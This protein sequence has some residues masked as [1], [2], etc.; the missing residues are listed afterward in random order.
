MK[1]QL[2]SLAFAIS[3]CAT[4]AQAESFSHDESSTLNYKFINPSA[5]R[6]P[7]VN[8]GEGQ[9]WWANYD[10]DASTMYITGTDIAERY[11]AAV[12]IPKGLLSNGN[13]TV[14][15]FSFYPLTDCVK[16]VKVWVC[17]FLPASPNDWVE[18]VEL[19]DTAIKKDKFNDVAFTNHH[20]IPQD[21]LYVGVTFEVTSLN[22]ADAKK[23][24]A[25][26]KS[27]ANREN[28]FFYKT[29]SKL[30]WTDIEGNAY[31]KVLFGGDLNKNAV[32]VKPFPT[33]YVA[34]GESVSVPVTLRNMGT[35]DVESISY[36]ITTDG[37][38]SEEITKAVT[39]KGFQTKESTEIDF[40]GDTEPKAYNKT[41]TITKVNGQPNES[42]NNKAVGQIIT[43]T[44]TYQATP[45]VE[46]FV[47]TGF[48]SS[49]S[50]LA[51]M[52]KTQEKYGDQVVLI[53]VHCK[54]MNH[55]D[56]MAIDDYLPLIYNAQTI[57][58]SFLDR[59]Y[60]VYPS[61]SFLP[62]TVASALK[63]TVP[64]KISLQAEWN[65]DV[66]TATDIKLSSFSEFSYNDEKANYG[67][68]YVILAD[69]LKGTGSEWEQKNGYS[70]ES[71]SEDM[72][73]W[74]EAPSS[75]AGIE[76]DHVAIAAK[77]I[78]SGADI[79]EK[80]GVKVG[81]QIANTSTI[82]IAGNQLVQDKS[83]LSAV[84][85]LIDRSNNQIVNAAKVN[86]K[87]AKDAIGDVNGDGTID[88]ADIS[89]IISVM[90][91]TAEYI[92][93]DVNGDGTVDVADI[94][95]VISIMAGG[96]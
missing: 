59:E 62:S 83:K 16:N 34:K 29:A 38:T 6:T 86:I 58:T 45:V 91:G 24:L 87:T 66:E 94:S 63:R 88:V 52:A 89:A 3:C 47:G 26:T 92:N 12:F 13:M 60:I 28:S 1:K 77:D 70:G 31:V 54:D 85:L 82:S 44:N 51:G 2:L 4:V 55:D 15:G 5:A 22:D 56:P 8:A 96:K 9:V 21:G 20:L 35:A 37:V 41:L 11:D 71:G 76:Y 23:P 30:K 19:A 36:T 81:E 74:R 53:A 40:A 67:V 42:A 18:T 33:S 79:C 39:I 80:E 75:V 64:A 46:V 10:L 68:A 93:A 49:P 50:A 84:A 27:D 7:V 43:V 57:P 69:G 14:D 72:K 78:F 17:P 90:A 25:F 48:S 61:P 65:D 32:D 95:S 73:F